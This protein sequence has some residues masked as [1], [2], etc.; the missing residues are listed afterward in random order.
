LKS[1]AEIRWFLKL[2]FPQDKYAPAHAAKRTQ[3]APVSLGVTRKLFLPESDI[4]HGKLRPLTPFVPVPKAAMHKNNLVVFRKY[5]VGA[6][7]QRPDV[8]TKAES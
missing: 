5:D 6:S 7:R 8:Q 4:G 1:Q 3:V 2:A